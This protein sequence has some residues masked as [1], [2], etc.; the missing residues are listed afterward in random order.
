MIAAAETDEERRNAALLVGFYYRYGRSETA[1]ER[2][3]TLREAL[4]A[5]NEGGSTE[6]G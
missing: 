5:R 6:V 1:R 2:M 3:A 4:Q